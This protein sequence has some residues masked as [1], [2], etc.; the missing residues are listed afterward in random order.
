MLYDTLYLY[1]K[2]WRPHVAAAG[3]AQAPVIVPTLALLPTLAESATQA[4]GAGSLEAA[5]R[6]A[7]LSAALLALALLAAPLFILMCGASCRVIAGWLEGEPCGVIDA[8]RVALGHLGSLASGLALGVLG[9][10]DGAMLLILVAFVAAFFWTIAFPA[11][12]S[13]S[14]LVVGVASL[15]VVALA[16]IGAAGAAVVRWAVFVQA[17]ILESRGPLDALRRS[18][19]L[20]RGAHPSS[21]RGQPSSRRC[22]RRPFRPSA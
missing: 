3:L 2:T 21:T 13:S 15:S 9:L 22:L 16:A 4:F 18:S 8:Y 19:E 6:L 20:V 12:L 1:S 10:A 7:P 11:G 5:A 14:A 17:V